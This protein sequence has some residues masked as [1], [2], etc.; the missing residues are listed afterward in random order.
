LFKAVPVRHLSIARAFLIVAGLPYLGLLVLLSMTVADSLGGHARLERIER[1]GQFVSDT[2]SLIHELQKERGSSAGLIA[3]RGQQEHRER[4]QSQRQLTDTVMADFQRHGAD[5]SIRLAL[6]KVAEH[7]QRVD[8]L[9][10]SVAENLTIYTDIIDGLIDAI[11]SIAIEDGQGLTNMLHAL[12]ALVITKEKAGLERATGN[13]LLSA[14]SFNADIHNR[15]VAIVALQNQYY[16]EFRLLGG[17]SARELLERVTSR[18]RLPEH[19]DARARLLDMSTSR[20]TPA[21]APAQWWALTTTRVDALR[22]IEDLML[23]KIS[24][25]T[26]LERAEHGRRLWLGAAMPIALLLMGGILIAVIS[27]RMARTLRSSS[28]ALDAIIEGRSDVVPPP[29]LQGSSEVARI[30]NAVASFVDIQRERLGLAAAQSSHQEILKNT[31]KDVLNKMGEE[32][33]T[34]ATESASAVQHAAHELRVQSQDLRSA[35]QR[36]SQSAEETATASA[37]SNE[38]SRLAADSAHA[39]AEVM[40]DIGGQMDRSSRLMA[41]AESKAKV[42]RDTIAGLNDMANEIGAVVDLISGIAVQTNMLALNA[43]IEAARAGESGRGFSVVASEV[44]TL[45]N[46][47][48]EATADISRRIADMRAATAT[49]ADG[50]MALAKAFAEVAEVNRSMAEKTE[51]QIASIAGFLDNV[52][53]TA[54]LI[55][56]V[57]EQISEV[58]QM[59]T[60]SS[61]VADHVSTVAVKM[62]DAAAIFSNAVPHIIFEA[63]HK[64]EAAA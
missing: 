35:L 5:A 21:V 59:V 24:A 57:S 19:A 61:A 39:A 4:V 38:T 28:Q 40:T 17:A 58:T 55:G 7:R 6:N 54:E 41:E 22:E 47:T 20:T 33:L 36:I 64:A 18:L 14:V 10:V 60:R 25:Q 26:A 49:T 45:S 13:A 46:R 62:E 12:R 32:V 3:S 43:T 30:S 52:R 29:A 31:R 53:T 15:F 1:S 56:S 23:S 8:A 42:A 11:G 44:K 37:N 9:T 16:E 2:S 63:V 34:A 48:R 27:T 50:T 51:Q